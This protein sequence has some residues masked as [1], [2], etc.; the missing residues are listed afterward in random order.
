MQ[1][2]Q[3]YEFNAQLSQGESDEHILDEYFSKRYRIRAATKQEQKVGIDRIF[4]PSSD[5]YEYIP[6]EYKS[7][8]R[9]HITGNAFI[10]TVSVENGTKNI[11]G[12]AYTCEANIIIYFLPALKIAY[13]LEPWKIKAILSDWKAKYPER[14]VKNQGWITKGLLV[15]L[16]EVETISRRVVKIET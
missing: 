12:W 8:R 1:N 16:H 10:E 11:P 5:L 3:P 2:K 14:S 13:C 4:Y 15:P 7:D 6:V 9:A